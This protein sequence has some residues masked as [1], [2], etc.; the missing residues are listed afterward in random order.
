VHYHHLNAD[1]ALATYAAMQQALYVSGQISLYRETAPA[2]GDNPF[3][4]V[5]PHSRALV[6]SLALAGMPADLRQGLDV[7]AAVKDPVDGLAWYWDGRAY[8]SYVLPP[9]GG[10]GD[11]YADDNAWLGLAL[12]QQY[13]MGLSTSLKRPQQ[14]FRY[15]QSRHWDREQRDPMPGG[16][17]WVQQG[18]GFGLHNHDRGAGAT[19]GAAELGFH[20]HELTGSR[21]YAGDGQVLARPR[22][23]G[24][25]NMLNWVG[26]TMDGSGSGDGPFYNAMRADGTLDTNIWS[27]NQGVMLG[28]R[29][30]AYQVSGD[31]SALQAAERIARQTLGTFGDFTRQPPSFNA[32]CMQ[33]MLMLC[34]VTQDR[35]LAE[36]MVEVMREYADFTWDPANGARDERTNLF[37]FADDGGPN[38]GHQ[39]ARLQDQGALLQLYALLAWDPADYRHLT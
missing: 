22:A 23:L 16:L 20:L 27:Y 17:F 11:R 32:M 18:T 29:V 7:R 25:W 38:R 3:A 36:R 15:L 13:R 34:S 1:R 30:L 28:A 9:Y 33:N 6:G 5:W 2:T 10:G 12:V 37:Y 8:A 19:A 39:P 14:V 21:D 26:A 4:Y 35:A 24:A 31:A